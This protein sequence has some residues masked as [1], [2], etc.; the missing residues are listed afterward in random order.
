MAD[1][2]ILQ[3]HPLVESYNEALLER[4]ITGL[5]AAGMEHNLYRIAANDD[6]DPENFGPATVLVLIHPT[7]WGGLPAPLLGWVQRRLGPWIDGT[8]IDR[9]G[10]DGTGIDG[11]GDGSRSV[12]PS[13]LRTI[14]TLISVTTHGS[15]QW[16][17]RLQ[18]EP[19]RQLVARSIRPMCAKGTVHDW[20]ALYKLDRLSPADLDTFLDRVESDVGAAVSR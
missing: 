8:G 5:Q 12:A 10:I 17:N 11:P 4:T 19:G 2:V 20:I 13:P 16:V 15:A 1:A 3:C 14:E 18:G 9:T 7:W 6:P